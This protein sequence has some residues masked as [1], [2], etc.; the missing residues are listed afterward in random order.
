MK[1]QIEY[2]IEALDNLLSEIGLKIVL[3]KA[4]GGSNCL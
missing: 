3:E 1:K 4:N 2:D